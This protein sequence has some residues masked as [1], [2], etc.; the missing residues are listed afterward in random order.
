MTRSY[1][2]T[3]PDAV[4]IDMARA[5]NV[6]ADEWI[7]RYDAAE[8]ALSTQGFHVEIEHADHG[9]IRLAVV[10]LTK[11]VVPITD[12]YSIEHIIDVTTEPSISD[13]LIS[14]QTLLANT[15]PTAHDA[16]KAMESLVNEN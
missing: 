10:R 8:D 7:D 15:F 14:S 9:M 11:G 16:V 1:F 3:K 13:V 12:D 5:V 4:I 2:Y 6:S